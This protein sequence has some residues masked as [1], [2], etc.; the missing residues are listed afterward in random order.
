MKYT[1]LSIRFW[2]TSEEREVLLHDWFSGVDFSS[3]KRAEDMTAELSRGTESVLYG[4]YWDGEKVV[5][6]HKR[7][8][9]GIEVSDDLKMRTGV[10][11]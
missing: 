6:V 1:T 4:R 11:A 8:A 5:E 3:Y 9:N 10:P 7:F 2:N